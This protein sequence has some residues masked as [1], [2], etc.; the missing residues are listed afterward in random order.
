MDSQT[1]WLLVLALATPIGAVVGFAIQLR[2]VKK[3]RLEN[4]KLLLEIASLKKVAALSERRIMSATTDEVLRISHP[5]KP[6]FSRR[7]K[8]N[9]HA[10]PSIKPKVNFKQIL[11]NIGVITFGISFA[12]YAL[13]DGYRLI[14]WLLQKTQ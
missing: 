1:I 13:Y 3:V 10:M 14:V 11:L 9:D 4:E 12:S 6:M 5:D 8:I 7:V 2:Q